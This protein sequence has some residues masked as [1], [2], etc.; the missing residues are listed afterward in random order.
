[1]KPKLK[2]VIKTKTSSC[3][4]DLVPN[5]KNTSFL[6]VVAGGIGDEDTA[7]KLKAL[8]ESV[9]RWVE[10]VPKDVAEDLF[11]VLP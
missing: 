2:V 8:K 10:T 4:V 9:A 6:W 11:G 1:V 7:E 5:R 3:E